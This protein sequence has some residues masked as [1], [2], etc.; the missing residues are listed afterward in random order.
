MLRTKAQQTKLDITGVFGVA[1]RHEM[2]I[3]F[4]NMTMG[5]RQVNDTIVICVGI[6]TSLPGVIIIYYINP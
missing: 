1:C 5:E 2:P 3:M 6:C 4:L